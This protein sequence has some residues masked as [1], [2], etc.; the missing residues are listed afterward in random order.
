M[1]DII[2]K[3]PRVTATTW[4]ADDHGELLEIHSSEA[5]TDYV[6]GERPWPLEKAVEKL[7]KYRGEHLE[8]GT[9]KYRIV[10]NEDGGVIGRAGVSPF[11]PALREYELGYVLKP[12][13]WRQGL[14]TEIASAMAGRFFSLEISDHL[15]AFSD[16]GNEASHRVLHRI[17][18]RPVGKRLVG[19]VE[20]VVFRIGARDWKIP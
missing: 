13:Y 20:A 1:R 10:S 4:D 6:K 9:G 8:F 18:M 19:G 16:P 15:I 3:T 17:G 14:A 7:E 2:L 5:T 11:D 12:K